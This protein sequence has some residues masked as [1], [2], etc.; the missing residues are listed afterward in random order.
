MN[1]DA[2][3]ATAG[4][5]AVAGPGRGPHQL[6][7]QAGGP[8]AVWRR[9]TLVKDGL[10]QAGRRSGWSRRSRTTCASSRR[11]ASRMPPRLRSAEARNRPS[12]AF[13]T[14]LPANATGPDPYNR[15][16][17]LQARTDVFQHA[18]DERFLKSIKPLGFCREKGT[19]AP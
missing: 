11:L 19:C 4:A 6:R 12:P 18:W 15:L 3:F 14:A 7:V 13:E 2:V 17:E 9:G 8:D 5:V 10:Q 1:N 16:G